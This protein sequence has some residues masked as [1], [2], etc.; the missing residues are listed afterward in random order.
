MPVVPASAGTPPTPPTASSGPALPGHRIA[1]QKVIRSGQ[2]A[3][4]T[5]GA[6]P[7]ACEAEVRVRTSQSGALTLEVHCTCGEVIEIELQYPAG[8]NNH[9]T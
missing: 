7:P 9:D 4:V 6:N 1:G 5:G 2:V 8:G 3:K